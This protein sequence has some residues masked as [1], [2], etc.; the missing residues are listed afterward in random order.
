MSTLFFYLLRIKILVSFKSPVNSTT[1]DLSG[2]QPLHQRHS[3]PSCIISGP[4]YGKR[5]QTDVSASAAAQPLPSNVYSPSSRQSDPLKGN[6]IIFLVS[7]KGWVSLRVEAQVLTKAYRPYTIWLSI[8]TCLLLHFY[9]SY[10]T[11]S[12]AG[13]SAFL[14]HV[15]TLLP[16]RFCKSLSLC[17]TLFP[18]KVCG[19]PSHFLPV[20]G[21]NV[22]FFQKVFPGYL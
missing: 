22:I 13:F 3:G 18:Q 16:G 8:P 21:L 7:S 4:D 6:L 11:H 20:L 12:Q 5:P 15:H 10:F 19:W 9:D 14:Q 17:G 1:L 2:H